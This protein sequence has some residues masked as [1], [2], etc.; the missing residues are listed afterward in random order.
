MEP[1]HKK[2]LNALLCQLKPLLKQKQQNLQRAKTS[3]Q[4]YK[5][6][7]H[8]D[9]IIFPEMSF[10]GY[11]FKDADDALPMAVTAGEGEEFEFASSEAQRLNS[12][13]LF[14]Y[15]EK[16]E[17]DSKTT[18]YNSAAVVNRMGELELNV[19][20]THL[21]FNDELWC[22]E[23]D[24]FKSLV[25]TNHKGDPFKC[26]IGICMDIN[27]KNFTSGEFELADFAVKEGA[28]VVLF[29]TNWVDSQADS[30]EDSVIEAMYNYWLH[31]LSPMLNKK[32]EPLKPPALFLAADRVGTEYSYYDKKDTHFFGSSCGI[33]L[34]PPYLVGR[35]GKKDEG[36]LLVEAKLPKH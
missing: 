21:F 36:Y 26:I 30:V 22:S 28:E 15:V 24:G 5:K 33:M 25:L 9:I 17:K 1:E 10:T 7:N 16:E 2:P 6:E 29:P 23:G 34:N 27:P 14:G 3:L 18:L 32:N 12:Y 11:N 8:L 19:R 4:L 13:V 35:L 20:K 31:R